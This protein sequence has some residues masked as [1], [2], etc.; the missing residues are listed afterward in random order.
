L[1]F[2]LVSFIVVRA[3]ALG[4]SSS[5]DGRLLTIHDGGSQRVILTEASTIEDALNEADIYVDKNDAVEPVL[6]EKLVASEYDVNIYRARPV[7]V[8]DGVTKSKI[9]TPYQSAKQIA[10]SAGITL[11][12]GDITTLARSND[13]VSDGAGLILTI[14]RATPFTFTLYGKTSEVRTQGQTVGEMLE[15]K[16]LVLSKDDRLSPNP[17]TPLTT[18]LLV[19]VWREGRQTVTVDEPIDFEIQKIQDGDQYIGY[20][21]IR[22]PG[23]LG[24][25]SVTYEVVVQDGQEVARAEIASLTTKEPIE[26][27]EIVGA[28]YRGAY[29]TPSEN[30]NIT[31]D[32]LISKGFTRQQTAGIM[33][34]LMQEHHFNTIGDG[35]AQWTGPRKDN[36]LARPD[37]YNIYTQLDFMMWELDTTKVSTQQSIRAS[38]S[39]EDVTI[40]FENQF[41]A[42]NPIY[43]MESQRIQFAYNII[44]SH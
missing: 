44:A 19:R 24:G 16:G 29:T 31:W 23:Q 14:D 13:I 10:A 2:I 43:C 22:T 1:V 42:C 35:L 4:G 33:G 12:D 11:Y 17:S 38:S 34:N 25:R 20:R 8:V 6:S 9:I 37:P 30:E 36:L 32:Y 7:V 3:S 21:A 40:I 39:V 41:E 26:Q 15:E 28:K 27:V 5:Q 18:G